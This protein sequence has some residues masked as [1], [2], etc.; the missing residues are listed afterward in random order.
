MKDIK[1][2]EGLYAVTEDGRIWSYKSKIFMKPCTRNKYLHVTLSLNGEKHTY[3]VHRLVAEA[4]IDNPERKPCI[5]HKDENTLNNSVNNLE[6]VTHKENNNYGSHREKQIIS[7]G[8]QCLCVE[9]GIIYPSSEEAA[10]QLGL[11]GS[12]IRKVCRGK[13][14]TT[15]G[16]HWEYV[17]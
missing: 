14:R 11:C 6:W 15:G 8:K 12:N 16:Y 7:Q 5:N 17:V 2:Y 1:G 3:D 13:A 4:Y 9:T 10:R